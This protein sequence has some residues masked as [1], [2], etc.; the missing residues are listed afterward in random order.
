M[1]TP[2]A[3]PLWHPLLPP[4]MVGTDKKT[5]EAPHAPGAVGSLL[6]QLHAQDCSPAQALL[7]AAGVLAVC[8]RTAQRPVAQLPASPHGV[9]AQ[10]TAQTALHDGALIDTVRWLLTDAPLRLQIEGLQQVAA[11]GWRLPHSLL[12]L[13]LDSGLRTSAL[14]IASTARITPTTPSGYATAQPK[15]GVLDSSP[16]C[17]RVCC[18]A[19]SAGVLVVAPQRIPT[20]SGSEIFSP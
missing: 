6:G 2:H 14:R 20:M 9:A 18:A 16:I 5:F 15:A 3:T 13:A 4:A 12:P 19:P 7:Q 8:E 10:D 17:F 1:S 11:R